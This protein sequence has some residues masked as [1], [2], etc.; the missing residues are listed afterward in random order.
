MLSF[1]LQDFMNS[2]SGD[3]TVACFKKKSEIYGIR[4][5]RKA[6]IHAPGDRFSDGNLNLLTHQKSG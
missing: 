4:K 1:I 3:V 5:V 6:F 2:E